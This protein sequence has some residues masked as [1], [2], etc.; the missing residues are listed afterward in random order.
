[1]TQAQPRFGALQIGIVVLTITTALVHLYLAFTLDF[2]KLFLANGLGYL[3]LLAA[4]Y[5]PIAA[6]TP[7][8]SWARWGLLLYTAVTVVMWIFIGART[9]LAY[10]DKL[11]EAL[12]IVLLWIEDQAVRR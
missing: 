5:A 12:L 4:L 2:D 3:A 8:R 6:L 10:A 7:Y 1:M 9:P 11:V